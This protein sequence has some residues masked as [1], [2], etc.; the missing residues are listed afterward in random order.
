M[1]KIRLDVEPSPDILVIGISCHENDYRLCWSLNRLLG[2]S[3]AKRAQDIKQVGPDG[4]AG[5]T[6]FDHDDADA[7]VRYTLVNNHGDRGLL[8]KEQRQVDYF[9]LVDDHVPATMDELLVR[10]RGS[11]FVLA[12]FPLSFAEL[13]AGHKLLR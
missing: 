6:A 12:A 1:A 3:H 13:R 5:H 8:L 9:L 7:E 2:L 10:V 4:E 11:E